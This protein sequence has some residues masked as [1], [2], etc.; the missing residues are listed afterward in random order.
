MLCYTRIF[1]KT[2]TL[3][4]IVAAL[5]CAACFPALGGLATTI[6]L[7]F[8]RQFEGVLIN[9]LLP[10]FTTLVHVANVPA[11]LTHQR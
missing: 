8:L 11:Y 7:G 2:G 9:P 5:G 3:G 10:A 4:T 1:D 6:G